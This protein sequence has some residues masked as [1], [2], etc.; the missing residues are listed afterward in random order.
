MDPRD[1]KAEQPLDDEKRPALD[2]KKDEDEKHSPAKQAKINA[3][4]DAEVVKQLTKSKVGALYGDDSTELRKILL[5]KDRLAKKIAELRESPSDENIGIL[6]ARLQ[7]VDK[8]PIDKKSLKTALKVFFIDPDK[9][10]DK[11]VDVLFNENQARITKKL[12]TQITPFIPNSADQEVIFN[13]I[14]EFTDENSHLILNEPMDLREKDFVNLSKMIGEIRQQ[15]TDNYDQ[16]IHRISVLFE[17]IFSLENNKDYKITKLRLDNTL[18][19][20]KELVEKNNKQV[21]SLYSSI[22]LQRLTSKG[23]ALYGDHVKVLRDILLG[24]GNPLLKKLLALCEAGQ[25]EKINE[26][27]AR[28]QGSSKKNRPE[29]GK[30]LGSKAVLIEALKEFFPD[31]NKLTPAMVNK[32]FAENQIRRLI[33]KWPI[34]EE[35][36]RKEY[37]DQLKEMDIESASNFIKE[38]ITDARDKYKIIRRKVRSKLN[39]IDDDFEVTATE[40][41][42]QILEKFS[43]E[44]ALPVGVQQRHLI[45]WLKLQIMKATVPIKKDDLI[46]RVLKNQSIYDRLFLNAGARDKSRASLEAK[47]LIVSL[48][49]SYAHVPT[50]HSL[51]MPVDY[52]QKY[53]DVFKQLDVDDKSVI[54]YRKLA[55]FKIATTQLKTQVYGYLQQKSGIDPVFLG[56]AAGPSE[57]ASDVVEK[58]SEDEKQQIKIIRDQALAVLKIKWSEIETYLNLPPEQRPDDAEMAGLIL[59]ISYIFK[60]PLPTLTETQL[61]GTTISRGILSQE[62]LFKFLNCYP[63][64]VATL[65]IKT[66]ALLEDVFLGNDSSKQDE[67]LRNGRNYALRVLKQIHVH[68]A[69][70]ENK[71]DEN[72]EKVPKVETVTS[73]SQTL[74]FKKISPETLC[75]IQVK[76]LA[77]L[78]K[79][80]SATLDQAEK[81]FVA[82]SLLILY[83]NRNFK[84]LLGELNQLLIDNKEMMDEYLIRL[85]EH[86]LPFLTTDKLR[87]A[88]SQLLNH[89]S[90]EKLSADEMTS[91]VYAINAA[92]KIEPVQTA[93]KFSL[94]NDYAVMKLKEIN[95]IWE[96][97]T[98]VTH[99]N[100]DK[101]LDK[102]DLG[103]I[104]AQ[105]VILKYLVEQGSLSPDE[106]DVVAKSLVIASLA[107][108][109]PSAHFSEEEMDF[110][111]ECDDYRY[112]YI[113]KLTDNMDSEFQRLREKY[114]ARFLDMEDAE[115]TESEKN[116]A[117]ME[118]AVLY[119]N[120]YLDFLNDGI[121]PKHPIN[122]K[123]IS[124]LATVISKADER[125]R[126]ERL[127]IAEEQ[128]RK[129]EEE[130]KA[131]REKLELIERRAAEE[132][133]RVE[134]EQNALLDAEKKLLLEAEQRRIEK[135][136]IKSERCFANLHALTVLLT[137][138]E[139]MTHQ[140]QYSQADRERINAQFFPPKSTNAEIQQLVAK[141]TANVSA[142]H[143]NQTEVL[144]PKYVTREVMR[145]DAP[146]T[147]RK[148]RQPLEDPVAVAHNVTSTRLDRNQTAF[149]YIADK[150]NAKNKK[151]CF[152]ETRTDTD[153][154]KIAVQQL[155]AEIDRIQILE[156]E[157]RNAGIDK[158]QAAAMSA[159][160][161]SVAATIDVRTFLRDQNQ[162][163]A[164]QKKD[165][166][167]ATVD[168]IEKSQM[169]DVIVPPGVA[170]QKMPSLAY[171]NLTDTICISF[172]RDLGAKQKMYIYPN[173]DV[174]MV[175]AFILMCR[176]KNILFENTSNVEYEPTAEAILHVTQLMNEGK[177]EKTQVVSVEDELQ[178]LKTLPIT[179]KEVKAEVAEVVKQI[180]ENMGQDLTAEKL[181]NL[182]NQVDKRFDAG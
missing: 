159:Q 49:S 167:K 133:R 18:E 79:Y 60:Y 45:R 109:M 57:S 105:L 80:S 113:Q 39:S 97:D 29:V 178:T 59:S 120:E 72:D 170:P 77:G 157:L 123:T 34:K 32:L 22:V 20:K 86:I 92:A 78:L 169:M 23:G 70:V 155:P 9:L 145:T 28:L 87:Y 130:A 114:Q 163:S 162:L 158:K 173:N 141:I 150:N 124:I 128:Q 83:L 168:A 93:L 119:W 90:I 52:Y 16:S 43:S 127:E 48:F 5:E 63:S 4:L 104:H 112:N 44:R 164:Q 6:I 33:R 24:D 51:A 30:Y 182:I 139:Q 73:D 64:F 17:K 102:S 100:S 58:M 118:A 25:I 126:L 50:T 10:T 94:D 46:I 107:S 151:A 75:S 99:Y 81:D 161:A 149:N 136:T 103:N 91:L 166:A 160:Y 27:L 2:E 181:G 12:L 88:W 110:L 71:S 41:Y 142:L 38:I 11:M 55:E 108:F 53:T 140:A 84:E 13:F 40:D 66:P 117:E 26:L 132:R 7:G 3:A 42:A 98:E 116:L 76:M 56:Q 14:K 19:N 176:A 156:N 144:L 153:T 131:N 121:N 95:A 137:A 165:I 129:I 177:L 106:T 134:E 8:N 36:V 111:E 21:A 65:A 115:I 85:S 96:T 174:V 61:D 147:I 54:D 175:Q 125:D 148:L 35:I 179:N 1:E 154:L 62:S 67:Q 101:L 47:K 82:K 15:K 146:E 74:N 89:E 138:M 37:V 180:E 135:E 143:E 152:T 171:L 69:T 31:S 172:V 68:L 122:E